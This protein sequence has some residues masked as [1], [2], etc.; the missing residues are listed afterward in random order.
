[1]GKKRII[2][3]TEEELLKER[4]KVEAKVKKETKES[5]KKMLGIKHVIFMEERRY[6]KYKLFIEKKPDEV[7]SFLIELFGPKLYN[8]RRFKPTFGEYLEFLESKRYEKLHKSKV[9]RR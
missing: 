5:L 2:Q 7:I 4:D 6:E 8:F 9:I 3:Q 1:M